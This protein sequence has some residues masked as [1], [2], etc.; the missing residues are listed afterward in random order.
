LQTK[1]ENELPLT[2]VTF[3]I[4]L[5]LAHEPRHGYAIMTDVATL[6]EGRVQLSTGTLYGAFKRLL[7]QGW[8]ER[9]D[10]DQ[11]S[12]SGRVRKNYQL[13]DLGRRILSAEANR[14]QALATTAQRYLKGQ[15]A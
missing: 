2:E 8:I 15:Q 7:N 14:L 4:L 9:T 12:E 6:S 13:T 11:E 1:I 10:S 5:S 3:F